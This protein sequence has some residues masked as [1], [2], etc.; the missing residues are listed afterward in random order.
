MN[1]SPEPWA[2]AHYPANENRLKA[3]PSGYIVDANGR[4]VAWLDLAE[5]VGQEWMPTAERIVACVNTC[6]GI[7]T[8]DLINGMGTLEM[9]REMAAERGYILEKRHPAD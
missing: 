8:A 2:V 6:E 1:H 4:N 7:P 9:L 3:V 5:V